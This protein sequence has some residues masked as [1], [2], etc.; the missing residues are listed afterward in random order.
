MPTGGCRRGMQQ[1]LALSYALLLHSKYSDWQKVVQ[2]H[3][4][5]PTDASCPRFDFYLILY[6]FYLSIYKIEC[7]NE[8]K[9]K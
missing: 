7:I 3:G 5:S 6:M 4:Y 9:Y 8:I 1:Q 2:R